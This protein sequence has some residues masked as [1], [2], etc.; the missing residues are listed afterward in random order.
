MSSGD[1]VDPGGTELGSKE[2]RT[3]ASDNTLTM[4]LIFFLCQ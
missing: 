3:P 1:S 2:A 4:Q